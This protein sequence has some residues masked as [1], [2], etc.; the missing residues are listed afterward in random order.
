MLKNRGNRQAILKFAGLSVF[1][2][3][4]DFYSL[5]INILNYGFIKTCYGENRVS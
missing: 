2:K 1:F 5:T 3:I 4:Y